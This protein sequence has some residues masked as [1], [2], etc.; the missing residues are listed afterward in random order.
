MVKLDGMGDFWYN[1]EMTK[2]K[3]LVLGSKKMLKAG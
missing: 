3:N 2:Q 1:K